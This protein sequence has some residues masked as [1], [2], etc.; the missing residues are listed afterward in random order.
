M[1]KIVL[2]VD[3]DHPL[4]ER[5]SQLFEVGAEGPH[6]P[7]TKSYVRQ[8]PEPPHQTVVQTRIKRR[9]LK[10]AMTE[11]QRITAD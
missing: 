3:E 8:D 2:Q 6:G 7:H 4:F 1:I 9:T 5:L 11:L 10:E